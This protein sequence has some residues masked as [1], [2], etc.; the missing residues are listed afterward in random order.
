MADQRATVDVPSTKKKLAYIS[1]NGPEEGQPFVVQWEP[2]NG[3][4]YRLLFTPMSGHL[5]GASGF[6]FGGGRGYMVSCVIPGEASYCYAFTA[7]GGHL[8]Y[9]YVQEKLCS[10]RGSFVDASELTRI[11][12]Q[13][14]KRPVTLATDETGHETRPHEP[15]ESEE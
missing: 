4:S 2:G 1:Y 8:H 13:I 12:G 10:K 15:P 7:G 14:L 9:S 11:I 6:D 5:V 3:T